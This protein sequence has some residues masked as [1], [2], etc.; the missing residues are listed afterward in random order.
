MKFSLFLTTV[1]LTVPCA[2]APLRGN[3]SAQ[4][5]R[6]E[7]HR[8]QSGHIKI[9]LAGTHGV[10]AVGVEDRDTALVAN[11]PHSECYEIDIPD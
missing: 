4:A 5:A 9:Y 2:S 3:F 1:A 7:A 8:I 6:R 10:Y 11:L